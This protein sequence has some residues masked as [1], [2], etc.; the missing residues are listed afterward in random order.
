MS[1]DL[2]QSQENLKK[3]AELGHVQAMH[4]YA[5]GLEKGNSG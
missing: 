4:Y 2:I 3:A 1:K 5:F